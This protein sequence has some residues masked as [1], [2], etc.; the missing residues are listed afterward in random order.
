[1][2]VTQVAAGEDFTVALRSNGEVWTWGA[3][4]AGQLGDGTLTDRATP[5]RNRAVYGMTQVSAGAGYALARRPGSVWAW[6]DNSYGALGNGSAAARSARPVMV[7]RRRQNATQMVA[8]TWHAF[9]VDPDGSLWAWGDNQY[10][11]L[12]LGT[13]GPAVRTPQKVPGLA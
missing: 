2:G 7:D 13:T 3:N 12:G 9:A 10:G 11:E 1:S 5:A 6:R 8:G 4:D